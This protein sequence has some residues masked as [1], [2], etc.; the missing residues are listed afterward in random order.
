MGTASRWYCTRE[1]VKSAIGVVGTKI[2]SIVDSLIESASAHI[3]AAIGR[4]FIPVTETRYYPWPQPNGNS[5]KVYLDEDLLSLTTLNAAAQDASPTTIAA[6][7]YFLEPVNNPPYRRIEID[8]SSSASFVSGDTPQRSISV[9]GRWGYSEVT[10]TAGATAENMDASETGLDVT[11]AS[12]IDVGDTLLI[13]TEAL[14]V[15][16]R[17][18]LTTTTTLNDA[19]VTASM[20][21]VSITVADGTKVK[22]GE[23]ISLDF[24]KMLV[25]AISGNVLTVIRQYDGSTLAAHSTGITIYAGRTLTVVRGVNG[26]TAATSTSGAAITKY[27]PPGDIAEWCRAKAGL[28]LREGAAGYSNSMGGGEG[29]VNV[30]QGT[31]MR[32]E[33]EAIAKYG[34]VTL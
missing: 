30:N 16:G 4:R 2:D 8:R 31:V 27:A 20:S 19:S 13:G 28:A 21:N 26:T 34:V 32:M 15:S 1:S 6:S 14:F 29:N 10:K 3:E 11:D 12:L 22:A 23:V 25:E 9:L 33:A 7:D 5:L 18:L 24:E 17:S